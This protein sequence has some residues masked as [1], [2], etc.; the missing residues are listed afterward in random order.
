MIYMIFN[1]L[2]VHLYLLFIKINN[3]KINNI[4]NIIIS[5]FVLIIYSYFLILR[6]ILNSVDL[7]SQ[8][9]YFDLTNIIHS[10]IYISRNF[11]VLFVF[12]VFSMY[13]F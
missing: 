3:K 5:G 13:F 9:Y 4:E 7:S 6:A 12:T 8:F 2:L 1:F 11:T 10:N